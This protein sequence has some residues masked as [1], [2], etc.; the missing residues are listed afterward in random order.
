MTLH[1]SFSHT[2]LALVLALAQ[3]LP[4]AQAQAAP[5]N[6]DGELP[7]DSV[8][9]TGT[10]PA[11]GLWEATRGAKRVLLMGTLRPSAREMTWYSPKVERRI[12]AAQVVLAAPGVSVGTDIGLFRGMMLLPAYQ[13]SKRNPDG[14]TLKDVL[15]PATYARWEIARDRYLNG[16]RS[17]DQLRP[18][19]AAK[20]LF[21]A[22]VTHAGMTDD[23][24]VDPVVARV[25]K[26]HGISVRPTVLKL[27]IK[28]PNKTLQSLGRTTL[29]D[30]PCLVQTLDRLDIDLKT[31]VTRANAWAIG[32]LGHLAAL[33]FVDQKPAC[34]SA[35]AA[36]EIARAQGITDLDAQVQKHWLDTMEES[37]SD[38]DVVFA[39]MPVGRLTQNGG[40]LDTLKAAGFRVQ[41]PK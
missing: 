14:K 27:S 26:D 32:D 30:V 15:P 1:G 24:H 3:V 21:D 39:T 23:D 18:V 31:M 6:P 9:V 22:A 11:P 25:A 5:T 33:P 16:S 8:V 20:A 10:L 12:A 41:A 13:R 35:L 29:N 19:H 4:T 2:L 28:D 34:L 40:V 17:M 36:N 38:H 7:L 37:L